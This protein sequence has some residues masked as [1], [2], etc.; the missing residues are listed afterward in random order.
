MSNGLMAYRPR[1]VAVYLFLHPRNTW[2]AGVGRLSCLTILWS[3]CI[4]NILLYHSY[5][6]V[7]HASS[8]FKVAFDVKN[9]GESP[10]RIDAIILGVF[11]FL[12]IYLPSVSAVE[13]SYNLYLSVFYK[14]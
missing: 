4:L 2:E 11:L 10:C 13:L 6:S 12:Y 1:I 14:P 3:P 9:E 7:V 5:P 8:H